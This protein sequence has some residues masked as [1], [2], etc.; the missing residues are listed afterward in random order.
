MRKLND[1]SPAARMDSLAFMRL[2]RTQR[3]RRHDC[4]DKYDWARWKYLPAE[5]FRMIGEAE[6][7][8]IITGRRT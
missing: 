1:G 6:W 3:D 7:P 8:A 4:N 5:R 2:M